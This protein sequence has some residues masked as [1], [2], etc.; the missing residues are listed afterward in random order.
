MNVYLKQW[1]PR[2]TLERFYVKRADDDS[3]VGYIQLTYK[4]AGYGSG[5]YAK[6]R[7]A[8]GDFG[9]L[10]LTST[11]YVGDEELLSK[12][13]AAALASNDVEIGNSLGLV[14]RNSNV[15]FWEK[16]AARKAKQRAQKSITVAI[17]E[18]A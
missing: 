7:A 14:S 17:E 9:T 12:V 15:I 18:T 5:Q 8:K 2:P 6:H 1:S 13:A 3:D 11:T 10:D 16:G 4:N